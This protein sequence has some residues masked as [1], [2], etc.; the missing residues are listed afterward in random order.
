MLTLVCLAGAISLAGVSAANSRASLHPVKEVIHSVLQPFDLKDVRLLDGPFKTAQEA[1]GKYL[2]SLDQDRLLWSFR[3]NAGLPAPG[4]PLGGWEAPDVEVRGHFVGHY[5]SGCALMYAS[6]GEKKYKDKVDSVVGELAKCQKALGGGYLSAYPAEFLDR[7]EE[8][9]DPPWAPYY[10][11]HKIMAGMYDAYT[12]CG[13]KQALDVVN[14]M[15]D[16]ILKRMEKLS[17]EEITHLLRVE[18]GGMNDF[19][20]QLY[21]LTGSP[22]HL[23][24]ARMFDKQEFLGPLSRGEDNLTRRHGN[25]HIPIVAGAARRYELTDEKE[26]RAAVEFF[27]R[28]V[29][30]TRTYCM[31]GTTVAERWP[32]AN[33]LART[34]ARNNAECCKTYN[35]LKLTRHLMHWTGDPKYADFYERAFWNGIQGSQDPDAGQLLYYVPLATGSRKAFGTPL[36]SFWCCY[37]TGVESFAKQ[38]DSIYFHDD[39]GIYVNL[40]IPSTVQWKEKGVQIEQVTNF[41]DQ[42]GTTLVVHTERPVELPI[43][44]HVP[45]W[46]DRG[47]TVEV[48]GGKLDIKAK[49]TSYMSIE[50]TWKDGDKVDIAMP[51]SLH[52]WPMPDK[53]EMM[54][55]MYGPLVLA[56]LVNSRQQL[57]FTSPDGKLDSW[58][59]PVEG[60][61]LTFRTVGQEKDITLIPLN[62]VLR[63]RYGVYW[64]VKNAGEP[65]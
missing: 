30:D 46:A 8:M 41:P 24:L 18:Y 2:C 16:C 37:G 29:V 36:D 15:A 34:L 26:S 62:R 60:K 14:A 52:T 39:K 7:L 61:T 58:I 42:E 51:M 63:Q 20:Y 56:G 28:L 44:V 10:T 49:L 13:N 53:P 27:W 48:N 21:A 45:Y 50:R 54:A 23:K 43:K 64:T 5:V 9:E 17:T 6:T 19:M 35:M 47:V 31:G 33:K 55:I 11:I 12:L 65:G 22:D 40:F 59:K 1:N 38:G 25:T 57:T 32:E 4:E 3:T